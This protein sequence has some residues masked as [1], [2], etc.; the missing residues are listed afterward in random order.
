MKKMF[1]LSDISQN[2]GTRKPEKFKV[3]HALTNRLKDSAPI[4]MEHLL[5]EHAIDPASR[6]KESNDGH[7]ESVFALYHHNKHLF[8]S[9]WL[10][11]LL[12]QIGPSGL[13]A[14]SRTIG[15]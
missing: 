8:L 9:L 5:N 14:L 6:I 2:M 15:S 7:Y 4:Y 13:G 1:P 12:I 11:F 3:Q 10:R